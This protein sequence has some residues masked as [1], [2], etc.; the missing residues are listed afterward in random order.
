M[1][2]KAGSSEI[3][4]EELLFCAGVVHLCYACTPPEET[5]S[6]GPVTAP[7]R[8]ADFVQEDR[9]LVNSLNRSLLVG[10]VRLDG[11]CH[12]KHFT[13]RVKLV[14]IDLPNQSNRRRSLR[15]PIERRNQGRDIELI[16]SRTARSQPDWDGLAISAPSFLHEDEDGD[17]RTLSE[18]FSSLPSPIVDDAFLSEASRR[19]IQSISHHTIP[20]FRS[21]TRLYPYQ[22]RTLARLLHQEMDS[23]PHIDP[24]LIKLSSSPSK[25]GPQERSS[26]LFYLDPVDFILRKTPDLYVCSKGGILAEELGMGK[27]VIVLALI[28]S[29]RDDFPELPR[30]TIHLCEPLWT[31][32]L[33]K[34]S[35]P[36]HS[37]TPK[38]NIPS[39]TDMVLHKIRTSDLR[40][41]PWDELLPE[42]LYRVLLKN[43]P[44]TWET[45]EK[46][47]QLSG[48]AQS[49]RIEGQRKASV[50]PH[51]TEN[52]SNSLQCT[53]RGRIFISKAT[54]VVVPVM[55][56][57]QWEGEIMKHTEDGALSVLTI[58][59]RGDV[60]TVEDLSSYYDV[61]LI[62][63]HV[64]P[65]VMKETSRCDCPASHPC[66]SPF[67]HIRWKRLVIDEGNICAHHSQLVEQ[68][69]SL[70]TERRWIVT[71]T[72]TA[73]L[74]GGNVGMKHDVAEITETRPE[75]LSPR[76]AH[77]I[78]SQMDRA[79]INKLG[80]MTGSFLCTPP[81]HR[82]MEGSS[83]LATFRER[84]IE[85]LFTSR[86]SK[87]GS[88]KVLEQVMSLV[89]VRHRAEDLDHELD[90]PPYTHST[91]LLDLDYY[92]A[93][94]YNMMQ[95][96][97][98]VNA[99]DSERTGP[100]YLFSP[101]GI[102]Y[103]RGL[104][105]NITQSLFWHF[106]EDLFD[107]DKAI[108]RTLKAIETAKQRSLSAD[109]QALLLDAL[110][111][112]QEAA[113]DQFWRKMMARDDIPF[114][115]YSLP[116]SATKVLSKP[117]YGGGHNPSMNNSDTGE[118][119][120]IAARPYP[121]SS[122]M[123]AD[124]L[125]P[126]SLTI[127]RKTVQQY[128]PLIPLSRIITAQLHD[129]GQRRV[130]SQKP[131]STAISP[132]KKSAEKPQG[133]PLVG[134]A[135]GSAT[136]A[137]RKRTDR[138]IHSTVNTSKPIEV[139][140]MELNTSLHNE[141]QLEPNDPE[142]M[143]EV[144]FGS[145]VIGPS[146]ST[147]LDYILSE[148]VM[149]SPTEKILIFSAMPMTLAHISEAL[150][151]IGTDFLEFKFGKTR[152]EREQIVTTFKTSDSARVL[153]MEL[154]DGARG[155]NITEASRIIFCEPVW[156][157]DVQTQ[158]IKRAHR[159][160]QTKPI[161]VKT[162]AIRSTVEEEIMKRRQPGNN[163][164]DVC[165]DEGMRGF[166]K[167]PKFIGYRTIHHALESGFPLL[168]AVSRTIPRA[169]PAKGGLKRKIEGEDKLGM[170]PK[171]RATLRFADE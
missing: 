16:L 80:V 29:T 159:I 28:L 151:M 37:P 33:H 96:A 26:Q 167:N 17:H 22:R 52:Q 57:K 61:V 164:K 58:R 11:L 119:S 170:K 4:D 89:I 129:L 32:A 9:T 123:S 101:S 60:P 91:I 166:I 141:M 102:G 138:K 1:E 48:F 41:L 98:A 68:L 59:N 146:G 19:L 15:L 115:V 111:Y 125:C 114:R 85:P 94:T 131:G 13:L 169:L 140:N 10:S 55:L 21:R 130:A 117:Y 82:T 103:L 83:G 104:T 25:S 64:F 90:L 36:L 153:L 38:T 154:K 46:D 69:A 120:E 53:T 148:V 77:R 163:S 76:T 50:D 70:N 132:N 34:Y 136:P 75:S 110:K 40:C 56:L 14:P 86:G 79:D 135:M 43:V 51:R 107:V 66:P 74:V 118:H 147:K 168:D 7:L 108:Q 35:A 109:D 95:T 150:K 122:A 144:S 137:S 93:K 8:V 6:W 3:I 54:L 139:I 49:S 155:L 23:K 126:S 39:L 88:R 65:V 84:V 116:I 142:L 134:L 157:L 160:G 121:S 97:I 133:V 149:H 72:P 100:D 165:A 112:Q 81:F 62:N 5:L 2:N 31:P 73:N 127:I 105:E 47:L 156:T 143:T 20:G 92:A 71:G 99:V 106:D 45:N 27:T 42:H 152:Y 12:Q 162:L 145:T 128:G 24:T 124:I 113:Q 67:L 171:K 30:D 63:D 158:A 78:W 87:W 44:F 18:I 161:T